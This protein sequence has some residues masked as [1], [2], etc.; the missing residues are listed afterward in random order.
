MNALILFGARYLFVVVFLAAAGVGISLP[1][2]K[3][4]SFLLQALVCGVIAVLLAKAAGRLYFDPRPFTRGGI[5]LMPHR[6]DNG[7][8]SD[9]TVFCAALAALTFSVSS[10]IGVGLFVLALLVGA[11]RV[12]AGIHSP[13]DIAAGLLIGAGA[14]VLAGLLL[15]KVRPRPL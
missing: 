15:S 14:A 5:P 2:Q 8:P 4:V 9:H 10:K 6:P 13:L 7:F 3:R 11:S 1:S 12:A